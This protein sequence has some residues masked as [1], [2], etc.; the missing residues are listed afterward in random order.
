MRKTYPKNKSVELLFLFLPNEKNSK[1]SFDHHCFS[2]Y[3]PLRTLLY[4]GEIPE[5]IKG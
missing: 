3:H 1:R 2:V 4:A 5:I